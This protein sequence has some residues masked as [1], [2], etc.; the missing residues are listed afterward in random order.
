MN[1]PLA[2]DESKVGQ[3]VTLDKA[4]GSHR[5]HDL[6]EVQSDRVSFVGAHR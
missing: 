5:S 4:T 2:F 3:C 1:I 6:S